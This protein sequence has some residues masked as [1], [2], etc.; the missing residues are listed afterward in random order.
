MSETPKKMT[1]RELALSLGF[2]EAAHDDPIYQSGWTISV[3]PSIETF[4]E[5]TEIKT[6][7]ET[8]FLDLTN[9]SDDQADDEPLDVKPNSKSDLT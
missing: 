3:N 8:P 5:S 9:A 4:E 7:L 2:T 1:L 6:D